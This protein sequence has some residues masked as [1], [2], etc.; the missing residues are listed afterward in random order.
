VSKQLAEME[1]KINNNLI[2]IKEDWTK[3]NR[4]VF[5]GWH[6]WNILKQDTDFWDTLQR[7]KRS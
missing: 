3:S 6:G 5:I 1:C 2:L 4:Q 7:L